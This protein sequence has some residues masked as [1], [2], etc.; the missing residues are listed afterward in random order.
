[1][2]RGPA[3]SCISCIDRIAYTPDL[4]NM[5]SGLKMKIDA[6]HVINAT[7]ILC[8]WKKSA[9]FVRNSNCNSIYKNIKYIAIGSH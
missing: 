9:Q 4:L 5:P 8:E 3:Y 7:H 6:T 1:M 2:A